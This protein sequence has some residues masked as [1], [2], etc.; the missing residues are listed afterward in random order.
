M[1]CMFSHVFNFLVEIIKLPWFLKCTYPFHSSVTVSL[2]RFVRIKICIFG[3]NER[4]I[5][6]SATSLMKQFYR[7]DSLIIH[8][9]KHCPDIGTSR[10]IK[11]FYF[12]FFLSVALVYS[13]DQQP[14]S[15][16]PPRWF[17]QGGCGCQTVCT[18]RHSSATTRQT[19]DKVSSHF[20]L[21]AASTRYSRRGTAGAGIKVPFAE[22]PARTEICR[23]QFSWVGM[24]TRD[25]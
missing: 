2:R 9:W 17:L 4:G 25:L 1:C 22:T 15:K 18:T 12:L 19:S 13:I 8:R 10:S 23:R 6:R 5:I 16:R 20:C 11:D 21:P 3:G 14:R 7:L 24:C